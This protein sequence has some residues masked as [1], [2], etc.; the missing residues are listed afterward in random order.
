MGYL[1]TEQ[2]AE[3]LKI[4]RPRVYQLIAEKKLVAQKFG[5]DYLIKENSLKD[6]KIHGK[7]GRPI[8]TGK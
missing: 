4:S 6:V 2:V 3:K 1:T 8:K 5:R 7:A